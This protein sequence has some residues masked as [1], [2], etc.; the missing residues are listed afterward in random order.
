MS[1]NFLRNFGWIALVLICGPAFAQNGFELEKS[2]D[3]ITVK[4]GG[5]LFTTYHK[6]S[7][8]KPVMF[9][10][11]GPDQVELTRNY[12]IAKRKDTEKADH[13]HHRSFWF[14]HGNVNGVSYWHENDKH[15][16]IVHRK[17]EESQADGESATLVSVNDWVDPDGKKV[18]CDRREFVFYA[19]KDSRWID[20]TVT[21]TANGP[22]TFGDTKEGSFGLRIAGSMK[23]DSGG[24]IVNSRGQKNVGAW[25]KPAEW[26]DYYGKIND[27]TYGI[28]ILNH[29]SSYGYPSHWHVR[30]YGLFAANPFG[31]HDFYGKKSGKDGTLKLKDKEPFSLKYRV[32]LHRGDVTEGKV[33]EHFKKY[34]E[35]E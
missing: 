25:G 10:L 28:A 8:A 4:V 33:A 17:F 23:V 24:T 6:K 12:P 16:N 15:G 34:S 29:K 13:I 11:L 14:T 9:P 19:N 18:C 27:K 20:C 30:T 21:V 2:E 31:L 7:G 35:V 22:V 32:L 26:V 5:K 1:K 3:S